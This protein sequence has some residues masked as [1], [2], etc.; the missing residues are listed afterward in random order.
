MRC[1]VKLKH[2]ISCI[3]AKPA[4]ANSRVSHGDVL[5]REFSSY[6]NGELFISRL[7]IFVNTFLGLIPEDQRPQPSTI[8]N[9]LVLINRDQTATIYVNEVILELTALAKTKY[10]AGPIDLMNDLAAIEDAKF[11]GKEVSESVGVVYLFSLGWRKGLFFDLEPLNYPYPLRPYPLS[12][13]IARCLETVRLQMLWKLTEDDW[14]KFYEAKWFPFIA[15]SQRT[16][17]KLSQFIRA[18]FDLTHTVNNINAEILPLLAAKVAA[19]KTNPFFETHYEVLAKAVERHESGDYLCSTTLFNLRIEGIMKSYHLTVD[20]R[21]SSGQKALYLSSTSNLH[22]PEITANSLLAPRFT[23]YLQE[24]YFGPP[25]KGGVSANQITRNTVGH[26]TAPYDKHT[27]ESSLLGLLTVDQLFFYLKPKPKTE[28]EV[29][30][31]A[32]E[33]SAVKKEETTQN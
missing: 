22:H 18:G 27:L 25:D 30:G 16:I 3:A 6:E 29:K 32:G 31:V 8:D 23:R 33:G 26:G 5:V 11:L 28:N 12:E 2:P 24:V 13:I 15:L 9:L 21:N 7:E 1:E 4:Q 14:D 19:W 10:E 20:T 17:D